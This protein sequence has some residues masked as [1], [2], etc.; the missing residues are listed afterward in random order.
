MS[1]EDPG[2]LVIVDES[3]GGGSGYNDAAERGDVCP[4][5]ST[6]RSDGESQTP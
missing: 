3:W 2:N 4:S 1:E 5:G 6:C